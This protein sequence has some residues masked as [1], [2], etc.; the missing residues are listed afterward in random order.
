MQTW[1]S[2]VL[3]RTLL[4]SSLVLMLASLYLAFLWA[5]NE[6][7]MGQVYRVFY[8]HVPV[9][10]VAFLAF[11]IVFVS[12]VLYLLRR[13]SQ[14]DLLAKAAAELGVLLTT[15]SLV[16]GAI[17]AK[18]TWG[19]WWT[20]DPRGTSM[21]LLWMIYVGYLMVRSYAAEGQASR[22]AAVVG[23]V[24]FI[25][26]PIVYF[27]VWWWQNIHPQPLIRRGDLNMSWE[28]LVTVLVS[29]VAFTVLFFYLLLQRYMLNQAEREVELMKRA[30][31]E[32]ESLI[33]VSPDAPVP[34]KAS[35]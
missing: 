13:S 17:W 21:L 7:T 23:I 4:G 33:D 31:R 32:G 11:F 2:S 18:P 12:S 9:S 19:V 30:Y 27:S 1:P 16:T 10:W 15:L 5:P 14:W 35:R 28:M 25:D 6:L 34:S 20:W 29:A 22:F 8:V 26:V 24:G 3:S